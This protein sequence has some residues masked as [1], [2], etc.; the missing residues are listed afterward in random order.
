MTAPISIRRAETIS[1]YRACQRAQRAA[2][3]ITDDSYVVPLATLVGAQLH[4]GLVLGAFL[5]DGEAVGLSFAFLGRV[6]GRLCLYSQLT[7]VVPGFQDQGIGYRLKHAQREV[8]RAEQV[9]C[10]A[11]A[12]DPLQAGN[13]RF[14]LEK[15]GARAVRYVV[16]MYGTRS[17]ALNRNATTDRL[18]AIWETRDAS[19]PRRHHDSWRD[20]PRALARDPNAEADPAFLG[21]PNQARA[22]LIEVPADVARLRANRPERAERWGQAVREAFV[23]AFAAGFEAVGFVRDDRP[24]G[25]RCHYLLERPNGSSDH[26]A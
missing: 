20:L 15:L 10:I 3:G 24:E 14:N 26:S 25:R 22:C 16:D 6:E 5:P 4:G 23:A 1:E 18:I 7:G 9:P 12:F 13:A 17:D 21:L 11:W 8:A 19:R 2:W